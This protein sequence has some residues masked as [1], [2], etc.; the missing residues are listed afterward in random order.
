MKLDIDASDLHVRD[1]RRHADT[2]YYRCVNI[3]PNS[4]ATRPPGRVLSMN[5]SAPMNWLAC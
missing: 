3:T 1:L 2:P 5:G 4:A